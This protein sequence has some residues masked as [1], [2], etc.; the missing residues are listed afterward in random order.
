MN[1]RRNLTCLAGAAYAAACVHGYFT[2]AEIEAYGGIKV[3]IRK[4]AL[5]GA[6]PGPILHEE[7]P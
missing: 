2:T 6:V 5:L 3:E 4:M 7:W 1:E